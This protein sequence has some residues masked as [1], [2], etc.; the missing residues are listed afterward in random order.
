MKQLCELTP[1]EK[2]IQVFQMPEIKLIGKE[3]RGG[4]FLGDAVAPTLWNRCIADGSLEV[5]RSLP[6]YIPG[7]LVGWS[8]NYTDEDK[9]Y[10]YIVGVFT[11]LDTPVPDGYT[12]RIL[13]PTLVGKGR[14]GEGYAFLGEL[15]RQGYATNYELRGWNVELIYDVPPVVDK[16]TVWTILSPI[17]KK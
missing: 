11:T 6:S 15:D 3:I 13:P 5:L 7:A 14:P 2:E 16:E 10:S 8:G 17:R 4:G 1:I 12:F 9:T